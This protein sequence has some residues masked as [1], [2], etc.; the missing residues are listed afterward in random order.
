MSQRKAIRQQVKT[1]LDAAIQQGVQPKAP[2]NGIGLVLGIPGARF[3]TL[4]DKNGLTQAGR[5]YYN[6]TGIAPPGKF[7]YQQDSVRKGRSQYI[8][9]LDGTQK[10]ISTW[11]RP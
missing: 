5:Y 7:D 6:K 4:Y 1:A 9:L 2:R 11:D 3:R 10:K 8:K